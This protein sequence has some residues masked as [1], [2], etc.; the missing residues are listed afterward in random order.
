MLA[1]PSLYKTQIFL[2]SP[3]LDSVSLLCAPARTVLTLYAYYTVLLGICLFSLLDLLKIN[4][5]TLCLCEN[6]CV[7]VRVYGYVCICV[8]VSSVPRTWD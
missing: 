6:V 7:Y 4:R 2:H 1:F 3:G 8:C 5:S